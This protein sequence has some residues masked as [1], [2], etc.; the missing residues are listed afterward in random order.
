[1]NTKYHTWASLRQGPLLSASVRSLAS[2]GR[3]WFTGHPGE[4]WIRLSLSG[5]GSSS[6]WN[7]LDMRPHRRVPSLEMLSFKMPL[8]V[9]EHLRSIPPPQRFSGGLWAYCIQS[10]SLQPGT[11]MVWPVLTR[12]L[13]LE[14]SMRSLPDADLQLELFSR[15]PS[16][17]HC[18]FKLRLVKP[19]SCPGSKK[20]H[21]WLIGAATD[22]CP[23]LWRER[24]IFSDPNCT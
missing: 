7:K 9:P 24:A 11:A 10:E 12:V 20:F 17:R 21:V 18:W 1:M 2:Y 22:F 3:Q 19:A 5:F 16:T 15:S 4:T 13:L 23:I 6:S 14:Q 8:K